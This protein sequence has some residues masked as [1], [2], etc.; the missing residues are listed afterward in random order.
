MLGKCKSLEVFG[1]KELVT[2]CK[3]RERCE[4]KHCKK[5]K[6]EYHTIIQKSMKKCQKKCLSQKDDIK[7]FKEEHKC[8]KEEMKKEKDVYKKC[9]MSQCKN[10][11]KSLQKKMEKIIKK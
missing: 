11:V 6:K 10:E 4:K 3:K 7:R 9:I 2:L 8:F 1:N 5:E